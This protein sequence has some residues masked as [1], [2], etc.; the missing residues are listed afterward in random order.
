MEATANMK[1]GKKC[2]LLARLAARGSFH[3][4]EEEMDALLDPKLYIGRCPV[5]VD[6]FLAQ[7]RPLLDEASTEKPEINL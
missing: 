3:M 2:D 5:Q 1:E 7:V 4:T 6:A